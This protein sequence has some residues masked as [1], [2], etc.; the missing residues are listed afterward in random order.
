ML[1]NVLRGRKCVSHFCNLNKEGK[2]AIFKFIFVILIISL[3]AIAN[4]QIH[5]VSNLFACTLM[6]SNM[7]SMATINEAIRCCGNLME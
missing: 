2:R 5:F 7:R 1:C 3:I 6:E 4:H